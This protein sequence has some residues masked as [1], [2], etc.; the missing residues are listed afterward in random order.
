MSIIPPYLK[1]GDTIGITCPA[2]YMCRPDIQPAMDL[3]QS[4]G[5]RVR[6]GNTID[7]QDYTFAGSDDQRAADLQDMLDDDGINAILFG[8][9]GYGTVRIIDRINFNRFYL[10]P[11]WLVGYSDITVLHSHIQTQMHIPTLH[12]EMCIDLL[13]GTLDQSALSLQR[14]LTGEKLSYQ[15]APHPL[16]RIGQSIGLLV[17]GNLSLLVSV[18]GS[19]SELGTYGKILFIEDVDEYLYNIDRMM[20]TLARAAKLDHLSGLVVGGF[21]RTKEDETIP[22][23]QTP[24]EIIADKLKSSGYPVCFGFPAGH[25]PDNYALKLGMPYRLSAGMDKCTL[26]E[27]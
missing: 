15:F 9:G 18:T 2:G 7:A 12:A 23:G 27:I 6:V 4:W 5:Y 19:A 24:E 13:Y 14:A 20:Y 10:K 1:P 21:T 16:N 22:F 26:E 25:Q 17:G 11:K 3:L 8:R